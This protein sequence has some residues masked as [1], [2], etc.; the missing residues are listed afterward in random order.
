[1]KTIMIA[2]L[3]IALFSTVAVSGTQG[4]EEQ[5]AQLIERNILANLQHPCMEV[6]AGTIQVL[7]DLRAKR[8]DYDLDFAILPIMETL[9]SD[10]RP[11][12]RIL[13]A[14]ALYHLDSELGRFAVERRAKYDDSERVARHCATLI[15]HWDTKDIPKSDM[16]LDAAGDSR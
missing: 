12:C 10:E 8:P 5:R 4:Q 13:A 16:L 2:T 6:R 11:E 14:L 7:I 15:R 9:K 1:M 3:C